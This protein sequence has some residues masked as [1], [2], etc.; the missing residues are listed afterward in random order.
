MENMKTAIVYYSLNGNTDMVAKRIAGSI[1]ADLFRIFPVKAYPDKG[2]KKFLWG[3]KS[4]AMKEEPELEPYDVRVEGYDQIVIGTPVWASTFT[5]PIRTFVKENRDALKEKK[6]AVFTC[7]SG[8]GADKAI[9]KLAEFIG[10]SGFSDKLILVDPLT[11]PSEGND[12][13]INAFCKGIE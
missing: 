4:A 3:G 12:A 7:F 8:G 2:V 5:P 13:L 10:V 1:G 6:L 9:A 11:K